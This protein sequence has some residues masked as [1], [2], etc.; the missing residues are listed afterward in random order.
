VVPA[1]EVTLPEYILRIPTG[2]F[3]GLNPVTKLVFAAACVIVAFGV[4]GWTG[5]AVVFVAVVVCGALSGSLRRMALFCLASLSL[6]ISILVVNTFLYPGA[7][8]TLA[9]VGPL[10]ATWTGAT[11][12]LQGTLRVVAF[13]LSAAL[14]ALT[15]A[16]DDLLV[17]LER[18]GLGRRGAYV[19]GSA[20][21]AVPRTLARAREVADAQRARGMDTEGGPWR[22]VRGLV[23]LIG[24]VVFGALGEVEERAMALEARAFTA[25]GRRTVLRALPD[26]L[27]QRVARWALLVG[28]VAAVVAS[29]ALP[30]RLP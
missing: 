5:P 20:L 23:P 16:I 28:S 10:T 22:R 9:V 15:T 14:F 8:D 25:P 19:V 2:P 3:R 29:L 17:E 12:A 21:G 1:T 30:G 24:P 4:R 26:S 6:L 13:G 7:H 11:A 27:G 18:R